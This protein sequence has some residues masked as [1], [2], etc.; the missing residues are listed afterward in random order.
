MRSA[1]VRWVLGA[2][3]VLAVLAVLRARPWKGQGDGA[4]A[5]DGS[6]QE[7]L[8]VGFCPVT[9]HLTCPVTDYASKTSRATRFESQRFTDFPTVV[10]T[11]KSGRL[12]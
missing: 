11:V 6:P 4:K 1:A 10:E 8:R 9:C 5:A 3:V 12:M 7:T 2:L